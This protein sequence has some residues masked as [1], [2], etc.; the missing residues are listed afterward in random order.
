M[1][2]FPF[3]REDHITDGGMFAAAALQSAAL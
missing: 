1:S 3:V 2:F